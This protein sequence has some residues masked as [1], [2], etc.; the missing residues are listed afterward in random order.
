MVGGCARAVPARSPSLL[1]P[2]LHN[3]SVVPAWH[4]VPNS[5]FLYTLFYSVIYN[6]ESIPLRRL[7]PWQA[8]TLSGDSDNILAQ[9]V[10]EPNLLFVNPDLVI[11]RS[12][13]GSNTSIN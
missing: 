9:Y 6:S 2:L 1:T 12:V 5:S 11:K 10:A 4:I 7:Q 13:S 3:L 8:Q